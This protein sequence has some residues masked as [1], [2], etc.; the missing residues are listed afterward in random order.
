MG[1]DKTNTFDAETKSSRPVTG[2]KEVL[3]DGY[4]YDVTDFVKRHPGGSII[5]YY[6]KT[7]EDA[8]HAIQQFHQR[9]TKRVKAIM[10]SLRRRPASDNEIQSDDVVRKKNQAL[11]EDFTKLYLELEREGLFKP[12]YVHNILRM[13]ELFVIAALGYSLLQWQNS[14]AQLMGIFLIGLVQ[15]RSGW[16]Q[17]ESGHHSVSG[18]PYFDRFFHA[19]IFGIGLGLSS[20]WW[21]RGHNRHHAMPQRLNHDVDLDT[22]PLL[23]YNAKVVKNSKTG[24][25]FMIQN[26]AFLFL[27]I[28]TL[29]GTLIW[30]IYIHPR[31]VLKHKFYLQMVSMMGHYV[32]AYQIGFWP[33][34]ISTWVMSVYLFAN[35]ALSHSFLPVTTEPTHWVEYSLIHTADVEQ[36]PWCNWWM[37]YLNYQIEHHLFPTMPQ[38]RHP[39]IKDRVKALAEKHNI[40]YVVHSYA[41]AVQKTF[42]NLSEVAK[43]LKHL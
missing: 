38:F 12:S 3:F 36:R 35:F 26:Q 31:F 21:S 39:R 7:G 42:K 23:A 10:S 22:L 17:H 27:L 28:D 43:E 33:W 15:G 29:L 8:T 11:S 41:E 34:L 13:A 32:L 30:Q 16:I 9:S 6:T 4:F 37:G 14:G 20:T 5:E 18:N 25:G 24:K 1:S 19:V 2:R 40:P